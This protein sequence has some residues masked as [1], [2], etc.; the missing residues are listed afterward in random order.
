M[1]SLRRGWDDAH[2]IGAQRVRVGKLAHEARA[3]LVREEGV[4][5]LRVHLRSCEQG[6]QQQAPRLHVS[7]DM[8][9]SMVRIAASP[10]CC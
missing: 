1:A 6:D 9:Q 2:L 8:N 7:V 10:S 5:V 3:I 4:I